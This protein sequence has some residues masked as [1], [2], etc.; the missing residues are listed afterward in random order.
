MMIY[1]IFINEEILNFSCIPYNYYLYFVISEIF[2]FSLNTLLN[3]LFAGEYGSLTE[4]VFLSSNNHS[5]IT[6]SSFPSS[7]LKV[8]LFI[9]FKGKPAFRCFCLILFNS[10]LKSD[11]IRLA[12]CS[13]QMITLGL[14]LT[15]IF[16]LQCTGNFTDLL[17]SCVVMSPFFSN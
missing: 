17:K 13:P 9:N 16:E 8:V 10:L 4:K 12:R 5:G 14:Y 3:F 15:G 2:D 7:K 11:A 6:I 1:F